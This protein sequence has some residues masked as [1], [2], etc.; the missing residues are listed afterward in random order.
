MWLQ[1]GKLGITNVLVQ[2][3]S[4]HH[5]NACRSGQTNQLYRDCCMQEEQPASYLRYAEAGD[6]EAGDQVPLE[7]A[8]GVAPAPVQHREEVHQAEP[9]LLGPRLVLVLPQR[10]VGEERLLHPL[11]KLGK[12]ALGRR[13][14]D[15]VAMVVVGAVGVTLRRRLAA[16]VA[17]EIFASVR[18]GSRHSC[19]RCV[20]LCAD[21]YVCLKMK[22]RVR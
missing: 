7:L 3:K 9:Q 15:L 17:I 4:R 8:E 14:P 21:G 19:G 18:H 5:E 1:V 11:G 12:D 13:E 20:R 10:V 6:G 22:Q 16:D 2:D